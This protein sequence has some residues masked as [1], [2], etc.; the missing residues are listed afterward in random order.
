MEMQKKDVLK[1]LSEAG[2]FATENDRLPNGLGTQLRFNNDTVITF[3]DT[4]RVSIQGRDVDRVKRL[5][6][7]AEAAAQGCADA[8]IQDGKGVQE[9]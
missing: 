2:I 1:L 5:L 6:Q 3:F 7:S 8:A 9:P 4:G